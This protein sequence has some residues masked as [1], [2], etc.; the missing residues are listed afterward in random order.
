MREGGG[1]GLAIAAMIVAFFA[2]LPF[3]LVV[4]LYLFFNVYGMTKGTTFSASTLTLGV[5]FT[6]I[7]VIT[8]GL[9][10]ALAGGIAMIG[11]SLSP[12]KNDGPGR[13]GFHA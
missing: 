8:A 13:R 2:F 6:G 3:V 7:A 10:A 4:L 9:V 11:K 1:I 5:V 12:S